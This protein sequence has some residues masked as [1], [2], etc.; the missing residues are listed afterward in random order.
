MNPITEALGV[1]LVVCLAGLAALGLYAKHETAANAALSGEN[2]TLRADLK[3]A[4][5][6]RQVDAAVLAS[7]ATANAAT[8][9]ESASA[10]ASL[11][12]AT[13]ANQPWADEAVPDDVQKALE[14][15]E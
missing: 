11:R 15:P 8:A 4:A 6:Q 12:T 2:T 9:R 13:Q 1:A 10:T 3:Q 5:E 14:Q 7:R